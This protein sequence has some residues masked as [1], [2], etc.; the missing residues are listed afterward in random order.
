M[1]ISAALLAVTVLDRQIADAYRALA[2]C[3]AGFTADPSG[4]GLTAC[5]EAEARLN[6][7]LDRRWGMTRR[8]A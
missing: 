8:A 3:R 7:L 5:E 4:A 6:A 2:D 1:T